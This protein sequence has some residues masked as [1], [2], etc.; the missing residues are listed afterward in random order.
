VPG[1]E[2]AKLTGTPAIQVRQVSK[3]YGKFCALDNVDLEVTQ[4][5]FFG[6]LGPNGAG[7][8]TL[9]SVVAGLA[10]ASSG[11]VSVMGHDVVDDYRAARRALGVVPQ[12]L[13]MDPFFTVRE[14]LQFQSGYF[15]IKDNAD[16]STS[17]T[18]PTRTCVSCPEA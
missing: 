8:T 15:G 3:R 9:I 4:G 7:K 16:I 14:T 6:L 12:E 17:L 13:V 10:R 1:V 11:Q 2:I 5:E 18:K